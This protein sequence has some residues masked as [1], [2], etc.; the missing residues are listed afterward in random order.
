MEAPGGRLGIKIW[1]KVKKA[2]I[3]KIRSRVSEHVLR[4]RE[5]NG[6]EG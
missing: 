5:P 3:L 1:G 2:C 4:R 6:K